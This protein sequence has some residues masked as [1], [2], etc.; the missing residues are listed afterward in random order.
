MS[1]TGGSLQAFIYKDYHV[2]SHVLAFGLPA[3]DDLIVDDLSRVF[4][5]DALMLVDPGENPAYAW[6]HRFININARA[7]QV[8]LT[9]F[10]LTGYPIY[11]SG[12][13]MKIRMLER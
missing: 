2:M 12:L 5:D 6:L 4:V 7:F 1:I 11:I 8:R 9:N 3:Q 10:K 13:K